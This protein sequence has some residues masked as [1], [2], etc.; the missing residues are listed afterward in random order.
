[1]PTGDGTFPSNPLINP[2]WNCPGCKMWIAPGVKMCPICKPLKGYNEWDTPKL[3][4]VP[5]DSPP[6]D[7]GP[8]FLVD[9]DET[10]DGQF[11]SEGC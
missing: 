9:E 1:M 5:G 3:P 6:Y 4:M 11:L 8:T 7:K 10:G 2:A